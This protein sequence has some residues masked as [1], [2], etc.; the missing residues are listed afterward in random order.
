MHKM[1]FKEKKVQRKD[2]EEA[3]APANAGAPAS[4]VPVVG[5]I[6]TGLSGKNDAYVDRLPLEYANK[7]VREAI[8]YLASAG[9]SSDM[10]RNV[11][12]ELGKANVAVMVNGKKASL[13]DKAE[14]YFVE[15]AQDLPDGTKKAYRE[16]EIEVS[17]TQSGGL[18]RLL[19]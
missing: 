12:R 2:Q 5:S 16:F 15:R 3:G 13:D 17:S 9:S 14:K 10:A 19:M 8:D 4:E 11:R 1:T 6:R 18:Y 7:T